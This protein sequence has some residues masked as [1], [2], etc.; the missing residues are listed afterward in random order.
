MQTITP[1]LWFDG[2]AEDAAKFYTSVFE[3]SKITKVTHYD[4]GGPRP[5]G[6]VL[7][8][9]FELNGQK[10]LGLNGGPEFPLTEAVSFIVNCE[11]QAEVDYYW[12]KLTEG[13]QEVQCGWLK[14]KFGLSWQITPTIVS[15]LI[16]DGDPQ[17]SQRVMAALR[18]MVKLDIDALQRAYDQ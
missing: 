2:Q 1:C 9:E 8:V 6:S 17:R 15:K 10:F 3:N 11:S 16:A 7:T 18:Q 14:D 12:E 4:E 13:G 5:A